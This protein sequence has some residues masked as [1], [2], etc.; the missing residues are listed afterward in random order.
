MFRKQKDL[1]KK[2]LRVQR[3]VR[4]RLH[5]KA[6]K[7]RLSIYRS[8][9]FLYCQ[10]IDDEMGKTLAAVSTQSSPNRND[11]KGTRTEKAKVLGQQMADQLKS[12]GIEQAVFDRGWYRYHGI[13]KSFADSVRE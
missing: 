13:V 12:L 7:P 3:G 9:R 4:R 5:G 8:N 6:E 10:A 1:K 11:L 2:R